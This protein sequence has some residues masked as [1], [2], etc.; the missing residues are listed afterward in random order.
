MSF[1]GDARAELKPRMRS[2]APLVN[3]NALASAHRR[4]GFMLG[5]GRERGRRDD[6]G[7]I[8]RVISSIMKGMPDIPVKMFGIGILEGEMVG[9]GIIGPYANR[10][11][12]AAFPTI[13]GAVDKRR[14]GGM[15]L[16]VPS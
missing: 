1:G 7:A 11:V 13:I 3:E 16:R 4:A 12:S 15:A 9:G 2:R 14:R 6:D 10:R 8:N 5:D